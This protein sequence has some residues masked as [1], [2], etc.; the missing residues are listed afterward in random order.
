[1]NY[2]LGKRPPVVDARTLKF[3]KYT[4]TL[5][6]VPLLV[7][8]MSKVPSF[9]MYLNDVEGD[10]VCA[11]AGH[12]IQNWTQYSGKYF[13]PTDADIQT[14][15]EFSGFDPG[16]PSTDQGWELL[17]ALKVWRNK[18]IGG[19]KIVAFAQLTTGDFG[20]LLDAIR[21]FGNAYLGFSLPDYVVPN[22]GPDWTTIRWLYEEGN[23]PDPNNGHCVPAMK[24][25]LKTAY[26]HR[27]WFV[28]WAARMVMNPPFY[29]AYSDEAWVAITQD[30]IDADAKSPSGFNMAA[31]TADLA[32]ITG[33]PQAATAIQP[34]SADRKK[35]WSRL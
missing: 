30:W 12:M 18:G 24:F 11:A 10:C 3:R 19:H 29:Q 5:P 9:P 17:P 26:G 14:F 6:P 28:S 4:T 22:S 31:L 23:P 21:I 8:F 34:K 2:R 1:M 27:V 25:S 15:Y 7:D 33:K 35:W 13:Q 16:N 20:E 32:L